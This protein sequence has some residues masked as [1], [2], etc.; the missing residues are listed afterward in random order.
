MLSRL[1][2]SRRAR[3]GLGPLHGKHVFVPP[4]AQG[5]SRLF[6]AGFQAHG[7]DAS[8]TPPSDEETL[9]LGARHTAGDECLPAKVTLG[10][11]LRALRLPGTDPARVVLFMP[12]ANGPC[13]F[14]QYAPSLRRT[15]DALGYERTV[16]LSLS[17]RNGYE[18]LGEGALSF[19]RTQWRA[20]VAAD[21][22]RKLLLKH[23]P[24]EE[25]AG[26][27]DRLYDACLDRCAAT[28]RSAGLSSAAQLDALRETLVACRDRFRTLAITRAMDT[29]R[30]G[31]VGEIFCRLNTFSN[32]DLIRKLE[33]GGA[34][35]WLADITEWVGYTH[36][37]HVQSLRLRGRAWSR[38]R[39]SAWL[40][41][42]LQRADEHALLAPFAEDF[43]GWEEPSLDEV[44]AAAQ[45][46]I[47]AT[48]VSGEMVLN[49]GRAV[50]LAQRGVHGIVDISPF[51]CMNG[52]VSEAIYPRVSRDLGG[53]PIRSFYFD[54]APKDLE[55]DVEV[56]L[57][58]ARARGRRA[59][60]ACEPGPG[61][62][63]DAHGRSGN[64][65]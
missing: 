18:V 52:I 38:E 27:A 3:H 46:Y 41:A 11:F 29:P 37:Q 56:F 22:L 49:V 47:P 65:L 28:L 62:G 32:E 48:A 10:D 13:R 23:R 7:I 43:A 55:T 40:R 24:H 34:E 39:L 5:S 31:V 35:T 58:L 4:M 64:D 45:P 60:A 42:R 61:D 36:V 17:S 33:A 14:G 44:F 50:C 30:I 21:I 16:I 53:L 54:G 2:T 12:T 15:L 25:E 20:L 59:G 6:C 8:P 26:E 19:F 63:G 51:T 1:P 9:D 57:E